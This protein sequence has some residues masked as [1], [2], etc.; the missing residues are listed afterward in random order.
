MTIDDLGGEPACIM[1]LLDTE[2]IMPDNAETQ[3]SM[4]SEVARPDLPDAAPEREMLTAF[5]D[6]HRATL[7]L[8]VAGLDDQ[9][10]RRHLVPSQTTLLGLVKHLSYVERTWFQIRFAGEDL[11]VPWSDA[12]PDADFRIEPDES[13][14]RILAFYREQVARSRAIV[15]ATPSLDAPQKGPGRKR[16]LRWI[17]VHM[18]EETAR[19]NGHADILRELIDGTTGE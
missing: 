17:L 10:L 8:K 2:G 6:W 5:L 15:A 16:T 13:T 3:E 9:A 14:E 12:D 11:P 4:A 7:L 1:A 18:I 19:H